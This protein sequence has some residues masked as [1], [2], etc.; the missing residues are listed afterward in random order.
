MQ[1]KRKDVLV[2]AIE[3]MQRDGTGTVEGGG[4][5]SSVGS[6]LRDG[7]VPGRSSSSKATHNDN[8]DLFLD[9]FIELS[10]CFSILLL[11]YYCMVRRR[12]ST[13]VL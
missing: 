8:E 5:I 12:S 11:V 3:M 1:A 6:S 4:A 7:G 9:I 2:G 10:T 13:K